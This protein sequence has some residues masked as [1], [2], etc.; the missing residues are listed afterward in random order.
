MPQILPALLEA[1][2]IK[3]ARVRLMD[4]GSFKERVGTGLELLR[5]NKIS[6]EKVVVKVPI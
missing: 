6:G 4:E 3:P 5:E 2:H 1:G